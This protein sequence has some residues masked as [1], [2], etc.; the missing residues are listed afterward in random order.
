MIEPAHPDNAAVNA[1]PVPPCP[2][3]RSALIHHKIYTF[4][5]SGF[6]YYG[7][8]RGSGFDI[9]IITIQIGCNCCNNG[10]SMIYEFLF[11]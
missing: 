3:R 6:P 9:N 7:R 1:M 4:I 5:R 2:F 10:M 8:C 11:I